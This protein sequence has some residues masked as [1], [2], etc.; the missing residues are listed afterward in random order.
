MPL[1]TCP[2]CSANIPDGALVCVHCGRPHTPD[3]SPVLPPSMPGSGATIVNTQGGQSQTEFPFFPVAT[4][5]L[6]VLSICTFGFYELYWAYKNWQRIRAA[7]GE[8][9]SPFWRAFFAPIWSFSLFGQIRDRVT[10]DGKP[11]DWS[12]P[13]LA[14]CYLLLS[15]LWRL[16][17]PWWLICFATFLPL[18]PV[19]QATQRFNEQHNVSENLNSNYN[20]K[21]VAVIILGGI[22]IS[23]AVVGSFIPE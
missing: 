8:V 6:V 11:A 3:A 13:F 14:T 23:L 22:F 12:P 18:I 9:L 15:G 17:D 7:S 19:Q 1:L 10:Q 21:N 20:G 16:P 2:D 5:K 4:H